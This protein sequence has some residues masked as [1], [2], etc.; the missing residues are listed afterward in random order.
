MNTLKTFFI[1]PK[2]LNPIWIWAPIAIEHLLNFYEMKK[3]RASL[4]NSY[5]TGH[6]QF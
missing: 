3:N 1:Q 5:P 4:S 2:K 6:T